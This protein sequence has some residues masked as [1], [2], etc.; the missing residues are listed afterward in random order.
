MEP[1]HCPA[2][3]N[4][5]L[6]VPGRVAREIIYTGGQYDAVHNIDGRVPDIFRKGIADADPNMALDTFRNSAYSAF[7]A[8][9]QAA[10]L[11]SV[12]KLNANGAK[13]T[14]IFSNAS[15]ALKRF[16]LSGAFA[17]ACHAN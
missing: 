13:G 16:P 6:S 17:M 12:N 11:M 10:R 4:V 7:L 15:V 3:F 14:I 8:G 9:Q 1:L 5:W 2:A